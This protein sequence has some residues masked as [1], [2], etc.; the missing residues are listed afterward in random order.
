[1][2]ITCFNP[3]V[4]IVARLQENDRI[5]LTRLL[6][7]SDIQPVLIGAIGPLATIAYQAATALGT[8]FQHSTCLRLAVPPL[9]VPPLPGCLLSL[10]Y[11]H[12]FLRAWRKPSS[13]S[14]T[15]QWPCTSL[16]SMLSLQAIPFYMPLLCT[17]PAPFSSNS[18]KCNVIL[19]WN[20]APS[21][22]HALPYSLFLK[23][24]RKGIKS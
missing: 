13:S 11:S 17:V 5:E 2:A 12:S 23:Q 4:L 19:P 22:P 10:L 9:A 1:M 15:W 7:Y 16:A 14:W 20:N 18:T 24:S 8:D 3:S 6:F 21:S